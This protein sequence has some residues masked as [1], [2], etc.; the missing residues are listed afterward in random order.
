MKRD[1]GAWREPE[2][3]DNFDGEHFTP[4][5]RPNYAAIGQTI[6]N[7]VRPKLGHLQLA[8]D[9]YGSYYYRLYLTNLTNFTLY[10]SLGRLLKNLLRIP[11]HERVQADVSPAIKQPHPGP[12][13]SALK[14]KPDPLLTLDHKTDYRRVAQGLDLSRPEQQARFRSLVEG[15]ERGKNGVQR[16]ASRKRADAYIDWVL[17][18]DKYRV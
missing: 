12:E 13:R 1:L 11:F 3:E 2:V 15:M 9:Q 14:H 6:D 18:P 7:D 10:L 4:S 8:S 16:A 5:Q 17:H